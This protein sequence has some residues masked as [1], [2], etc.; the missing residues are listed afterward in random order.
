MGINSP[1]SPDANFQGPHS[2]FP[3]QAIFD[4]QLDADDMNLL[5]NQWDR[6]NRLRNIALSENPIMRR[7]KYGGPDLT[8]G[9]LLHGTQYDPDRLK[10]IMDLGVVSGELIGIPEQDE[11]HYCA[12]FFRVPENMS[13]AQYMD[14]CSEFIMKGSARMKKDEFNYLPAPG[15]M[16]YQMAIIVD[17]TNPLLNDILKYDA[18]DAK[19]HKLMRGFTSNLVRE[20]T[21][22]PSRATS[23]LLVGIPGNFISGILAS[24]SFSRNELHAIKDI[25]GKSIPLFNTRGA[26]FIDRID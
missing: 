17:T 19:S 26:E 8:Q 18:Y 4:K 7:R 25:I 20:V 22:S 15:K 2:D 14:W 1:Q 9:T 21:A 5:Q 11:T 10:N 23:S 24:D 6:F 13:V 3:A 16:D 12:D